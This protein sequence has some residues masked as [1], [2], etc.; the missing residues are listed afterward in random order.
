MIFETIYCIFKKTDYQRYHE[1]KLEQ[2]DFKR[3]NNNLKQKINHAHQ[4]QMEFFNKF[5]ALAATYHLDIK[6]VPEDE[7]A[8]IIHSPKTLII[9]CGGDGTFL[10]CA[11]RFPNSPLLGMNSDFRTKDGGSVGALTLVNSQNLE[12]SI[13]SLAKGKGTINLWNRLGANIN[14]QRVDN[15]AVNDI[16]IGHPV[17]YLTCNISVEIGDVKDDFNCSG[18]LACTGMG[19][20]AWFEAAGGSHFSNELAAFGYLVLVPS[21]KWQPK[22]ISGISS[23]DNHI[24]VIPHRTGYVMAFDSKKDVITLKTGDV[25]DIFIDK[26]NPVKVLTLDV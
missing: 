11:Q 17:S 25:V 14:N 6:V 3:L 1:T 12:R 10:S 24:S 9:S 16:F 23:F 21:K 19:S 2:S 4:T 18:F 7:L 15:Y 20:N 5:M 13:S 8:S 26:D 22:F